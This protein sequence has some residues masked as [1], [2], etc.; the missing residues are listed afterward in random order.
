MKINIYHPLIQ[1][2]NCVD[3]LKFFEI[4]MRRNEEQEQSQD[5]KI[6]MQKTSFIF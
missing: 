4:F 3:M 5:K 2:Y 6:I 1:D